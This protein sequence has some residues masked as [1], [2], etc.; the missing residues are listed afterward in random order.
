MNRYAHAIYCDDIR[1]EVGGK[2]TLVGIYS[3]HCFVNTI[4]C[5]LPKLCISLSLSSPK[6]QPIKSI[7]AIGSFAGNEIINM[8]LNEEQITQLVAP[9]STPERKGV[10]VVLLAV[11][12]PF[13]VPAAGKLTLDLKVDGEP[14][15][16][17]ALV[18]E[19]APPNSPFG[20]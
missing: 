18:I 6:S 9:N 1:Q 16:C 20:I 4:P 19:I 10:M 14:I 7:N 13:N 17:E 15:E 11:M 5:A 8:A 12:S 2:T 3:G